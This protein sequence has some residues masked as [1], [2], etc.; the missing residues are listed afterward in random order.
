VGLS[1]K[2]G[3]DVAGRRGKHSREIKLKEFEC[4]EVHIALRVK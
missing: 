2:G 4:E 3:N 1:I